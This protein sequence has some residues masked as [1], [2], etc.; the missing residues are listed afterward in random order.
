MIVHR[1]KNETARDRHDYSM[2]L[3]RW[4]VIYTLS[5]IPDSPDRKSDYATGRINVIARAFPSFDSLDR[6]AVAR[7]RRCLDSCRLTMTRDASACSCIKRRRI[8][9]ACFG[10]R[11]R[12]TAKETERNDGM[13]CLN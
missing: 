7:Y 13:M 12:Q 10:R 8:K 1:F 5:G 6:S 4:T 2:R 9:R 3:P 11:T